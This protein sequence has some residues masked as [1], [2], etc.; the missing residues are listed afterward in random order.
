MKRRLFSLLLALSMVISVIPFAAFAEETDTTEINYVSIGDSM[1]NGYGL[2]GYDAEAG[3]YDYGYASYANQFAAALAGYTT[4]EFYDKM[5]TAEQGFGIT[6]EKNG[7]PVTP[8]P[9]GLSAA[10]PEDVN[11]LHNLDY[12][13]P[14]VVELLDKYPEDDKV[15]WNCGDH[16]G[17]AFEDIVYCAACK[18]NP[19]DYPQFDL[20]GWGVQ[21]GSGKSVDDYEAW[22]TL[23]QGEAWNDLIGYG[24]Y[25]TWKELTEDYRFGTVATYIKSIFGTDT[26]KNRAA[27]LMVSRPAKPRDD[28]SNGEETVYVAKHF[29]EQIANAD[30]ISLGIGNGNF[31]VW[32]MGR[33]TTVLMDYDG[34]AANG[35]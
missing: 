6:F 13:E 16:S 24:D 15:C 20:P 25:W 14:E 10:R 28:G 7:V 31:G 34:V 29:Q 23:V 33:I 4:V 11:F 21:N 27:E 30:V 35:V 8:A 2:D 32:L 1:T 9:L 17:V 26:E 22:W 19:E 3:V 12:H 5:E 18:W